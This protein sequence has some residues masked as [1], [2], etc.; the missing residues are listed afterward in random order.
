MIRL[1]EHIKWEEKFTPM[2][3]YYLCFI[4][5][6]KGF[7]HLLTEFSNLRGGITEYHF[8]NFSQQ[9]LRNEDVYFGVGVQFIVDFGNEDMEVIVDFDTFLGKLKEVIAVFLRYFPNHKKEV[10][11]LYENISTRIYQ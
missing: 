9:I 5:S 3:A 11:D 6:E 7:I 2:L 8:C 1:T 4:D 10:D